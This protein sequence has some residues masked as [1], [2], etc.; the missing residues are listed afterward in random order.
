MAMAEIRFENYQSADAEDLNR[1]AIAAL[2]SSTEYFAKR[3]R[4]SQR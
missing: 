2:R 3:K 4:A 1:I